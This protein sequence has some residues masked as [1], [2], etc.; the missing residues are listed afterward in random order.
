MTPM[1]VS[2]VV[3]AACTLMAHGALPDPHCTPGAVQSTD[4]HAI[5]MPGWASRHR[6]VTSGTRAAVYRRYGLAVAATELERDAVVD[7]PLGTGDRDHARAWAV[8]QES[9]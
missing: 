3:A 9:A 2:A 8:D 5:C 6:H 7:L 1:L 4:A